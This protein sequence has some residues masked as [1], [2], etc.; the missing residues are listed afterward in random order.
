MPGRV[1]EMVVA[2]EDFKFAVAHF[3]VFGPGV[4]ELLHGHNYKVRVKVSGAETDELGLLLDLRGLKSEIRRICA[5]L[6]EKTLIPTACPLVT[7]NRDD[8]QVRVRFGELGYSL[9]ERSVVLLDLRNTSIEELALYVW[10]ELAPILAG[11]RGR[12]LEVEVAETPGQ[13]CN[14]AADLPAAPEE[15]R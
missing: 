10:R 12:R 8:G 5:S 1:Y 6:D 13:S 3:T 11:T 15:N 4:A 7:V 14:Y 9:A 2:K